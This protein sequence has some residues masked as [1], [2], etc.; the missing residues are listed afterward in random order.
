[1]KNY[2]VGLVTDSG[3]GCRKVFFPFGCELQTA[4]SV[5]NAL[6]RELRYVRVSIFKWSHFGC[7]MR[8]EDYRTELQREFETAFASAQFWREVTNELDELEEME[9][10]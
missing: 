4:V 8:V 3:F 10:K 2:N 1:M 7:W 5:Y 6:H 9:D